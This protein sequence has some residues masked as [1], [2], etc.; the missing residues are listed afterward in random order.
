MEGDKHANTIKAYSRMGSAYLKVIEGLMPSEFLDFAKLLP[1]KGSVLDIGCAGG[2]DSKRFAGKGFRVTGIDLV[3]T[4]LRQARKNVPEARFKK[5]DL[6]Q[7]KLPVN[8]F[9]GVWASA[10]LLHISK[11]DIP[12]VLRNIH[13]V[14]RPGGVIFI[15]VKKGKGTSYKKDKLSEEKRWFV[16]FSEGELEKILKNEGYEVLYSS[17]RKDDGGRKD[18]HWIRII[19]RK[20][21]NNIRND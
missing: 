13:K 10:V 18:T 19:A 12:N 15:Q 16:Y 11:K 9:D 21:L 3:D 4:F 5:M 6:L 8:S 2:R 20:K 14:L 17:L 7:L 1:R